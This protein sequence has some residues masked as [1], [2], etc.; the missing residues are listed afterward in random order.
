[1][2]KRKVREDDDK[3]I[4]EFNR[5][6][7]LIEF[8]V[9]YHGIR[10]INKL[11]PV[12]SNSN[13]GWLTRGSIEH[14]PSII[15]DTKTKINIFLNKKYEKRG[16]NEGFYIEEEDIEAEIIEETT[17]EDIEE[18]INILFETSSE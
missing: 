9:N 15:E 6:L 4:P 14:L 16:G 5:D 12:L 11:I 17:Q 3:T 8:N 13:D 18:L 10:V 2:P 7:S 1:M